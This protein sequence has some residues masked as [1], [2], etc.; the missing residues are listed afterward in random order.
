MFLELPYVEKPRRHITVRA[1]NM[2][3]H[4]LKRNEPFLHLLFSYLLSCLRPVMADYQELTDLFVCG[5][6]WERALQGKRLVLPGILTL[7]MF[8]AE[9]L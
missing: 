5:C 9:K 6:G 8:V 4:A 7:L 2:F 1:V 3:Q